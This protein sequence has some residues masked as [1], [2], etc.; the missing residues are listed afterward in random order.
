MILLFCPR[1]I[2][3]HQLYGTTSKHFY[4]R[5]HQ[6]QGLNAHKSIDT[7]SYTTAQEIL[8]GLEIYS[9]KYNVCGK[10]DMFNITTD[11]LTER[12]HRIKTIYDG[13]IFQLY[14]QYHC[15]TEMGYHV[16]SL[17]LYSMADNK[18]YI[19]PLPSVAPEKQN[20]F[21]QL[22]HD[23]RNFDMQA[24]FSANVNKCRHCVYNA[25]CDHSLAD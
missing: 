2:Y 1:S 25:L 11:R 9:E 12:K 23:L 20:A 18:T 10:L 3:F 4:H 21:E 15:L 17:G 7:K 22:L 6:T 5:D 13:Y 16:Q 24:P 19:V 14:A 8:M